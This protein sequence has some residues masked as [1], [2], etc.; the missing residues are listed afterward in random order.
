M[1]FTLD[2]NNVLYLL[3]D[4]EIVKGDDAINI[5]TGSV[6]LCEYDMDLMVMNHDLSGPVQAG[7]TWFKI[8]NKTDD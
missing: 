4:D 6:K 5:N 1:E 8:I 7:K 2:I 3:S